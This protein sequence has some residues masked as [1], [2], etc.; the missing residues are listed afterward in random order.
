M[1]V[2]HYLQIL[3]RYI[4]LILGVTL[5]A[6]LCTA[7]VSVQYLPRVY[8][9]SVKLLINN[10][11]KGDG[12]D[13]STINTNLKLIKTYTEVIR[14]TAVL[15]KVAAAYPEFM[16]TPEQMAEKLEVKQSSD[17]QVM[18]LVIR[19]TDYRRAAE[20]VN[21]IAYTFQKEIEN[22]MKVNNINVLGLANPEKSAK[23][24]LPNTQLNVLV[25]VLVTLLLGIGF[26]F[27]HHT[28]QHTVKNEKDV[29]ELL[30][31]TVLAA[32][33][34]VKRKDITLQP[35]PSGR[36]VGEIPYATAKQ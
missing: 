29:E 33:P 26:A 17:S 19:D 1:E 12:V 4:G 6:S 31:L 30:G 36:K 14:T 21:A 23:A 2:K 11:G 3:R 15:E 16:L 9:A 34:T 25:S 32:V 22:V 24:V 35:F 27:L 10:E 28:L 5:V 8:Q 13:I 18:T 7:L 20:T